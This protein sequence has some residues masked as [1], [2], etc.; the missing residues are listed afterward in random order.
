MD[1]LTL[2]FLDTILDVMPRIF[3]IRSARHDLVDV[4]PGN[5]ILF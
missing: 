2:S 1:L 5:K 4:S 3:F